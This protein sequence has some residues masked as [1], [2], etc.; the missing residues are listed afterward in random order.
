V[1]DGVKYELRRGDAFKLID[2]V[3]DGSIHLTVTSPPYNIGKAYEKRVRLDDYLKHYERFAQSLYAKTADVGSVCWQVGNFVD[4]GEVF[5]LDVYFYKF[6]KDAGFQLR[7][8]VVWHFEHGL[9]ATRRLSG[10][11]ETI[12]WF[13]KSDR[14]RFDLDPIRVPAKYPGKLAFK[15]KNKGMPTGNP[16]GKNPSDIWTIV[17]SDWDALIWDIPNVKANHPEKTIHPCQFPVELVERCV[18]ALTERGDVVFDPFL[19]VGTAAVAALGLGRSFVG[20]EMDRD[21]IKEAERRIRLL[22]KGQLRVRPLGRPV[23]QPTGRERVARPPADWWQP[24]EST[25]DSEGPRSL[26]RKAGILPKR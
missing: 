16:L 6:F 2:T 20:F 19:G 23:H 26:A 1:S 22:K 18:L 17:A 15:G 4:K 9:H 3:E 7:N 11:Y 5:P 8:R 21:Y 25:P 12:L 14:Y 24:A 10:R 13:S